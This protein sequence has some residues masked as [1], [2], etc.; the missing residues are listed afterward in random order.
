MPAPGSIAGRVRTAARWGPPWP[1][2]SG[3]ARFAAPASNAACGCAARVRC[4]GCCR[5]GAAG[6]GQDSPDDR[7]PDPS[8]LLTR[9]AP[10]SDTVVIVLLLA[11]CVGSGLVH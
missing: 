5:I 1:W 11:A 2:S 9:F 7:A 10:V 8:V 6:A 3:G 4:D